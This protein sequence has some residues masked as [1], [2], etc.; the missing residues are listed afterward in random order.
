MI[1]RPP[2]ST[3]FPYTTLFR[4]PAVDLVVPAPTRCERSEG[5]VEGD[6]AG[7]AAGGWHDVDLLVAVVLTGEG[8]PFAVGREFREQLDARVGGQARGCAAGDWR[9]PEIAAVGEG[10]AVAVD[11]GETEE[12][13]LGG[14]GEGDGDG[15]SGP[16]Q[17]AGRRESG[18]GR[19]KRSEMHI[20]DSGS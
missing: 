7:N 8:D 13:G 5:G 19:K 10:D 1:R 18:V 6:L 20:S 16:K 12:A 11:V 4:S 9:G 14:E 17:G 3:L 15:E 2:R